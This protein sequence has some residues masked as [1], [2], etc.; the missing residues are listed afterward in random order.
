[1][2]H[3]NQ[4]IHSTR[5]R[6]PSETSYAETLTHCSSLR[7]NAHDHSV[8][9]PHSP[10]IPLLS[11]LFHNDQVGR[12]DPDFKETKISSTAHKLKLKLPF[13]LPGATL[14][15]LVDINY[16]LPPSLSF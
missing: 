1:M 11:C 14:T 2:N 9:H 4:N 8:T 7:T 12:S 6:A 3:S 5:T 10:L 15:W 16:I 13:H